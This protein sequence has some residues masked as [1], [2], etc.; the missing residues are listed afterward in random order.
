MLITVQSFQLTAFEIAKS[1]SL[2]TSRKIGA[3][4]LSPEPTIKLI[5]TYLTDNSIIIIVINIS[6]DIKSIRKREEERN[7]FQKESNKVT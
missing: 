6:F 3:E 5:S 7:K 2:F 1:P 4:S